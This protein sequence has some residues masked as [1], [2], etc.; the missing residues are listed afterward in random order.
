M[1]RW[2][3]VRQLLPGSNIRRSYLVVGLGNPGPEYQL[4][5]HN[6]G[7]RVCDELA[8][9]GAGKWMKTK[10][11]ANLWLGDIEEQPVAL[12]KPRSYVNKSGHSVLAAAQGLSLEP[13]EIIVVHD[14]MD[15]GFG[16]LRLRSD[17]GAGG[18]NGVRSIIQALN[19][20]KF[21]RV[22]IG[23]GRPPDNVDPA[24][25]VLGEFSSNEQPIVQT[26]IH[27]AAAAVQTILAKGM[28]TA[29]GAFNVIDVADRSS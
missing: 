2:N 22:K 8:R 5:R 21:Q 4:T 27:E 26:A 20:G 10:Y 23:L 9:T 13:A 17:G 29:M 15:L 11:R 19:T 14:D 1:K 3:A 18:H 28:H 25:Y 12:L 24:T 6:V 16:R 7:F